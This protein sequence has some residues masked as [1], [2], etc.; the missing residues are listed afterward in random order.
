MKF[1]TIYEEKYKQ[2]L[3][4][5]FLLLV[6]AII[7]I[8]VQYT[9]T[10]DFVH[11]GITLKGGATITITG[12]L[13]ITPLDLETFLSQRFPKGEI[14][15]RTIGSV[16][17]TTGHVIEL[18]A[19][20]RSEINLVVE[21]L[22]SKLNLPENSYSVEVVGSSIGESFFK[23]TFI[24]LLIAFLLMGCVV[25]FYFRLAIPS[26]AIVLCAVSD[27]IV[28]LAIFNL[29]GMKLSS[30]GIAAFL[31]LVG[32]SVDT[33]IVLNTKVLKKSGAS[34]MQNIYNAMK[35]GLTMTATTLVAVSMAII[36]V[37]NDVVKQIMIILFIGLLVDVIMTYVQNA[38]ILR[39]Y[40]EYK[41]K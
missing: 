8:S 24:A 30:A 31:M 1:K 36:F 29:T 34:T 37:Q 19:Q 14:T 20:E 39:W 15:V 6:L 40:L 38:A 13:P 7:Q 9:T 18:D 11:K 17:S 5:P 25:L 2:L 23:Q 3:L 35:T 33:D 27:I 22:N 32:Y 28:T 21:T 4:I 41:Q 16:G 26:L 10:G 12:D